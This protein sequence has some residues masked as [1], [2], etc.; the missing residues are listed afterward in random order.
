M[1]CPWYIEAGPISFSSGLKSGGLV[2]GTLYLE[3]LAHPIPPHW[4]P[5]PRSSFYSSTVEDLCYLFARVFPSGLRFSLVLQIYTATE[6]YLRF[7]PPGTG[8]HSFV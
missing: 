6:T 2:G 3:V 7:A 8:L 5:F 1:T 4:Y